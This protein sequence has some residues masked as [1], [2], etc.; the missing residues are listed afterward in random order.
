MLDPQQQTYYYPIV[1][2]HA[3]K[4]KSAI[5]PRYC[6]SDFNKKITVNADHPKQLHNYSKDMVD[7]MGQW[8]GFPNK[9]WP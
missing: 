5:A 3:N 2:W 7:P 9:T 4:F 8:I 1:Y 6:A